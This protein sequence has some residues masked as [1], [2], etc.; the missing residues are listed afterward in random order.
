MIN[1]NSIHY[2]SVA[3]FSGQLTYVPNFKSDFAT[4]NEGLIAL[5]PT[6]LTDLAVSS[7]I[8][9]NNNLRI[10]NNSLDTIGSDLNIE[11]LRQGAIQFMGGLVAIDTNGNLSVTGNAT[12]AHDVTVDGQFATG[13]I[14]PIPN[15]DLVINLKDKANKSGSSLLITD[16][17]GSGVLKINQSGDVSSSGEA[18][19]GTIA[20][21][22]FSI[23]RGAQADTSVTQTVADSSAGKGVITT[24]ETERTIITPFVTAHSLIYI[25]ATSNTGTTIPYL[26]RQ[27]AED[28]HAG[29]KG[30]F[31]VSIPMQTTKDITFNWWIVN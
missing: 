23:V 25:T 9:V 26:A 29:T 20:S 12:F 28:A 21:H 5:G 7:T 1:I 8:S 17:T 31:T 14:A 30:S 18:N 11:P 4:F 2:A 22:G 3:S 10:T 27:T 19:F 13:V 15:Q 24:H 16:A 6:S